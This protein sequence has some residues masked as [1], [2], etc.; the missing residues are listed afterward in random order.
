MQHGPPALLAGLVAALLTLTTV[1]V[2]APATAASDAAVAYAGTAF[3]AT[4]QQREKHDRKVLR[5]NDCL[6]KYARRQARK[7]ANQQKIWHQDLQPVLDDCN[8]GFV[9]ENVAY[10]FPSGRSVVVDGWMKSKSHRQNLLH[11]KFRLMGLAA[12]KGDD[13]HWY[14]AQ[15]FGRRA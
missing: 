12:R 1:P 2:A 6:Q 8:M 11:R 15:V 14:A 4:N 10:G 7:M 9:G 13:G 3:K 5:K